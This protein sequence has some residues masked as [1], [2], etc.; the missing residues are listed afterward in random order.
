MA[1]LLVFGLLVYLGVRLI[2]PRSPAPLP[3]PAPVEVP[4]VVVPVEFRLP[5]P[6]NLNTATQEELEALPGIGPVLA[7]RILEYR[8]AHGP[9]TSVEELLAVSGIGE[10]LLEKLRPLIT[11]EGP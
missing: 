3:A 1:T 10:A 9:F 5:S 8:E 11:V 2:P 7:A 6:V 4:G